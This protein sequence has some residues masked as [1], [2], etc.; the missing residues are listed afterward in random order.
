MCTHAV[1]LLQE[2]LQGY[3]ETG[4]AALSKPELPIRVSSPS[5]TVSVARQPGAALQIMV[6]NLMLHACKLAY[7]YTICESC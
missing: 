2:G 7:L 4:S 3:Q 5:A 6:A 1:S